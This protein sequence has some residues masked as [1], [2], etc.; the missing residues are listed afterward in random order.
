WTLHLQVGAT[1]CPGGAL[2]A[3]GDNVTISIV[4]TAKNTLLFHVTLPGTTPNIPPLFLN[5][6]VFAKGGGPLSAGTPYYVNTTVRSSDI[7]C[8]SVYVSSSLLGIFSTARQMTPFDRCTYFSFGPVTSGSGGQTNPTANVQYSFVITASDN[9]TGAP[10]PQHNSVI[11]YATWVSAS[12]GLASF[13]VTLTATPGNPQVDQGTAVTATF[14]NQGGAPAYGVNV[15]FRNT[16][17]GWIKGPISDG[18]LNVSITNYT[19]AFWHAGPRAGNYQIW[20]WVNASGGVSNAAQIA[21]TVFPR[22]LLIDESGVTPGTNASTDTFTYLETDFNSAAIPYNTTIVP[23]GSS[24]VS[25]GCAAPTCLNN[26]DVIV[27]LLSNAGT[28]SASDQNVLLNAFSPG[29]RSVWLV[30]AG[31]GVGLSGA[32]LSDLGVANPTQVTLSSSAPTQL[33]PTGTNVPLN[34]LPIQ[35]YWLD[36]WLPAQGEVGAVFAQPYYTTSNLAGSGQAFLTTTGNTCSATQKFCDA[37]DVNRTYKSMFMPMELSAEARSMPWGS[38]TSYVTALG[39]Q[40]STVYDVFNWLGNFSVLNPHRSGADWAVSSVDVQPSV[41]TFNTPSYVNYTIRNNGPASGA[42][43]VELL[44]NGLPYYVAGTPVTATVNPSPLGGIVRGSFNWTPNEIGFLTVGVQIIPPAGDLDPA[45]NMMSNSLFAQ[46]LYV[47]YSV[48]LVDSTGSLSIPGWTGTATCFTATCHDTTY[49]VRNLL[50]ADGFPGN[51][52]S[53]AYVTSPTNSLGATVLSALQAAPPR[54]N[55]VVWNL[56]DEIGT[57]SVCPVSSTDITAL[58][59][60]LNNGGRTSS[61]LFVGGGL[62][63][64]NSACTGYAS[65]SA[66]LSGYLGVLAPSPAS[67]VVAGAVLYG[68][69]GN[70]VGNGVALAYAGT[71]VG[72]GNYTWHQFGATPPGDWKQFSL[73]YNAPDPWSIP[74]NPNVAASNLYSGTGGWHAGYWA[75]NIEGV[76][77]GGGVGGLETYLLQFATFSGRLLPQ[78]N[79]IVDAPDIT[80]ATALQPYMNFDQMHPQLNQQYLINANVTNLG[81]SAAFSVGLLLYDGS[82]ILGSGSVTAA[83]A[84]SSAGGNVSAGSGTLSFAWSPMFGATNAISVRITTATT[85]GI[86]PNVYQ[87]AVWN[88]TVYFFYDDGGAGENV[89]THQ[90]LSLWQDA[91]S[92]ACGT[93]LTGQSIYYSGGKTNVPVMW[94]QGPSSSTFQGYEPPGNPYPS[95]GVGSSYGYYSTGNA[96]SCT[97]N[98]YDTNTGITTFINGYIPGYPNLEVTGCTSNPSTNYYFQMKDNIGNYEGYCPGHWAMDGMGP[99]DTGATGDACYA[100]IGSTFCASLGILDDFENPDFVTSWA[101]SSPITIPGDAGTS[102]YAQWFQRYDLSA[103]FTGVVACVSYSTNGGS[104]WQGTG[105]NAA[106]NAGPRGIIPTPGPGYT[107]TVPLGGSCTPVSTFTGSSASGTF[108]WELE[109]MDLSQYAGDMVRIGWDYLEGNLGGCGGANPTSPQAGYWANSLDIYTTNGGTITSSDQVTPPAIPPDLWHAATRPYLAGLSGYGAPPATAQGGWLAAAPSGTGTL[110]LDPSMWDSLVTRPVSLTNAAGATLSF[111]YLIN[112]NTGAAA[113]AQGMAVFISPVLSNGATSWIQI[114]NGGT[115]GVSGTS[116]NHAG[117][118]SLT[119]YLGGVVELAFVAGTN[120]LASVG[121]PNPGAMMVTDV[122][123]SGPTIVSAIATNPGSY[124]TS[125]ALQQPTLTVFPA[126]GQIVGELHFMSP[127]GGTAAPVGWTPLAG[128]APRS[129]W[130]SGKWK[131]GA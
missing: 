34:A 44:V 45:N 13:S 47:H 62:V 105:S 67:S 52:I 77:A 19:T 89:W 99:A 79:A 68:Q 88:L 63:A 96:V 82:H 118:I 25:W 121:Y 5:Y 60:F 31:A 103:S 10:A 4:D 37:V 117:P 35:N 9:G 41:L 106:C 23:P 112:R 15:T 116:W 80:F 115:D 18:Q 6:G 110:T 22:T 29:Q 28:L 3:A 1:V 81:G 20:V 130:P 7:N 122:T 49:F 39:S 38:A 124:P 85:D 74:A 83:P 26:Y 66:F 91:Q 102:A 120:N 56:G 119:G 70:P 101:Y 14:T 54:F 27:W 129:P 78:P 16:G 87:Y 76:A 12:Q 114:W 17:T 30:G 61:L 84:S 127:Q 53:I 97:D 69:I 59:T 58:Q 73:Y 48:L 40:A 108:G 65:T 104:T 93:P 2:S 21:L 71:G 57:S 92:P 72:I 86:I 33:T 128:S 123:V 46:Q 36:G 42:F 50:L 126:P 75:F 90:Q 107:G 11:F 109:R 94:P 125:P 98:F 8:N 24:V 95:Y 111:D 100:V 43:T 64:T 131:A 55:L 51:T 113:P 32:L